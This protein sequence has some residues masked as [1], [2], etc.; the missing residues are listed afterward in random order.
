MAITTMSSPN[1]G[2]THYY[3]KRTRQAKAWVQRVFP[4]HLRTYKVGEAYRG[5]SGNIAT[6]NAKQACY[7]R[8]NYTCQLC[9][10][11]LLETP[12]ECHAHHTDYICDPHNVDVLVTLCLEC[13]MELHKK[14]GPIDDM[15]RRYMKLSR[16]TVFDEAEYSQEEID[17]RHK[18]SREMKDHG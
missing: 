9:G 14:W 12:R 4:N 17:A 5:L 2:I 18:L 6:T 16:F 11:N 7:D 8:D 13:H 3:N 15:S 1:T 10:R